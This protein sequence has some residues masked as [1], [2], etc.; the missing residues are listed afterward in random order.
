MNHDEHE[1]E[2]EHTPLRPHNESKAEARGKSYEGYGMPDTGAVEH[3]TSPAVPSPRRAGDDHLTTPPSTVEATGEEPGSANPA[4]E[5][6]V[7]LSQ[8]Q[9][10]TA[11]LLRAREAAE[12]ELQRQAGAEAPVYTGRPS[13]TTPDEFEVKDAG[14]P[15]WPHDRERP[16]VTEMRP[17]HVDS[18]YLGGTVGTA[19]PQM[20]G[21]IDAQMD[22]KRSQAAAGESRSGLAP[23]RDSVRDT[24]F[25]YEQHEFDK[26]A[27]PSDLDR[28]APDMPDIPPEG[29]QNER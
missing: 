15:E 28:V 25:D 24:G 12:E 3:S 14:R 23:V 16:P 2:R 27:P 8:G 22:V 20:V 21:R 29:A 4:L 11:D 1:P 18:S 10:S 13:S 17:P 6:T 7:A 9:A 19:D 26:P 5:E